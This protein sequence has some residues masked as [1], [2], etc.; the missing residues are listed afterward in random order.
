MSDHAP[1]DFSGA[2]AVGYVETARCFTHGNSLF[3]P[4]VD[5]PVPRVGEVPE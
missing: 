4:G 2:G 3:I 1:R 5:E